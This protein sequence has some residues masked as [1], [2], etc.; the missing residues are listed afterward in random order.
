MGPSRKNRIRLLLGALIVL[1]VAAAGSQIS[2]TEH[3]SRCQKIADEHAL[4]M[5]E[6]SRYIGDG[7][8]VVPAYDDGPPAHARELLEYHSRLRWKYRL[9]AWR[10]W[11]D[12]PP[13]PPIPVLASSRRPK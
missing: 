11:Q 3:W 13:D 4:M 10:P 6:I 9:A 8:K 7:A 5:E 1:S 2:N 12:V